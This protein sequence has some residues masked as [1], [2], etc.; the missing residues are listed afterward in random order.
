MPEASKPQGVEGMPDWLLSV[1]LVAP[2]VA[3][4]LMRTGQLAKEE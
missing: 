2:L 3:Q 1:L 4:A